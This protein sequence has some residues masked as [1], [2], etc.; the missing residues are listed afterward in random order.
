MTERP[1]IDS[2]N[3]RDTLGRMPTGVTIITTCDD[4]GERAG[5]TVGSFTSLS[6]DPPLVQFSLDKSADC[7]PQF[8]SCSHFAVNVLAEDQTDL[9]GIFASKKD[10]P[11]DELELIEGQNCSAPLLAGCV[12]YVECAHEATYPGGDHDIFVGR[13]LSL[14]IEGLDRRPLLF[15]GGTYRRL[16]SDV[17]D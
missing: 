12:A 14:R 3:Y 10:R 11:W 13:V 17:V 4:A 15:F 5:A 9:S 6:L 1:A 16:D 2:R 7:H 8:L